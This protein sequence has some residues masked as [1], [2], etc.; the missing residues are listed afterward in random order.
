MTNSGFDEILEESGLYGSNHILGILKGK[1]YYRGVSAHKQFSEALL[2][3]YWN[4]FL[5]WITQQ[6]E[7]NPN[8]E[9]VMET[10]QSN[11]K[12][13]ALTWM[14]VLKQ[15]DIQQNFKVTYYC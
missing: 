6:Y 12:S 11:V 9:E 14:D 1:H 2:R 5:N 15:E 3:L 7:K 8:L 4:S 10:F 13:F